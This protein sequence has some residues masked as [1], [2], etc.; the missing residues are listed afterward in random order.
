VDPAHVAIE[1]TDVDEP[2]GLREAQLHERQEALAASD[3]LGRPA[4]LGEQGEG[5]VE[6]RGTV[7]IEGRGDH[8]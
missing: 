1:A 8:A 5:V 6:A 7:V 4:V 2:L 3:D